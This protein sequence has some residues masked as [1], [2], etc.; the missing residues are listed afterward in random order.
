MDM[1]ELT[2]EELA[3]R[4]AEA[5]ARVAKEMADQIKWVA[6]WIAILGAAVIAIVLSLVLNNIPSR[7][8]APVVVT[9]PAQS[10]PAAP[11]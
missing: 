11:R 1:N 9:V 4:I 7:A 6:G 10:Q 8:A 5:E 3:A 2:R